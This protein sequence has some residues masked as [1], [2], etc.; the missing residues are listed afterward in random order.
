ML[1]SHGQREPRGESPIGDAGPVDALLQ[2]LVAHDLQRMNTALAPAVRLSVPTLRI[3]VM[4]RGEVAAA[5]D[6]VIK[7]FSEVDYTVHSRFLNVTRVT[8]EAVI[9]GV[10]TRPLLGAAPSY[11]QARVPMRLIATHDG[12]VVTTIDLWPDVDAVRSICDELTH[13][14]DSLAGKTGEMISTLRAT[15]PQPG[16]RVVQGQER[17]HLDVEATLVSPPPAAA[18]SASRTEGLRAPVPSRTRRRQGIIA[19]AV[20]LAATAAILGWVVSNAVRSPAGSL[21]VYPNPTRTNAPSPPSAAGG[22]TASA[23]ASA[24]AAGVGVGTQGTG[25][26]SGSGAAASI[27]GPTPTPSPSA[28]KSPAPVRIGA[29][30][31]VDLPT[32]LLFK[33]NSATLT[34]DAHSQLLDLINQVTKDHRRGS[35]KVVGFTDDTGSIPFNKNLSM[36]RAQ[37]VAAVLRQGLPGVKVYPSGEGE[38]NPAYPNTSKENQAKNRRVQVTL[39]AKQ[40]R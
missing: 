4:G 38:L 3:H 37:A 34:A 27:V 17:E 32:D 29:D 14:L 31:K 13:H 16:A 15:I 22:P 24:L 23:A 20:M 36:A 18:R 9:S 10:H 12:S 40:A 11:R 39:P 33:K 30:N 2:G 21:L 6:A 28:S 8:D 25:Q 26:A 35:I 7:A 5:M 1:H 19:G